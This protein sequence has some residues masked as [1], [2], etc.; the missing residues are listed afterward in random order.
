MK[1]FIIYF[2]LYDNSIVRYI[3]KAQDILTAEKIAERKYH[4]F[5]NIRVR[6]MTS[7]EV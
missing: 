1:K 4:N 2:F 6:Y 3:I 7:E 5:Y